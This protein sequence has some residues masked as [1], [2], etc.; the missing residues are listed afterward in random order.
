MTHGWPHLWRARLCSPDSDI[1]PPLM[2]RKG[3][4]RGLRRGQSARRQAGLLIPRAERRRPSFVTGVRREEGASTQRWRRV[5]GWS[6]TGWPTMSA[7]MRSTL[8][9]VPESVPADHVTNSKVSRPKSDLLRASPSANRRGRP[10]LVLCALHSRPVRSTAR[11]F[12]VPE[13]MRNFGIIR[14]RRDSGAVDTP[15]ITEDKTNKKS[16]V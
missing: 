14:L 5:W 2:L 1:F 11:C 6:E 13:T 7:S 8:Q 9:T 4:R 10:V 12:S 16:L 3:P 15:R